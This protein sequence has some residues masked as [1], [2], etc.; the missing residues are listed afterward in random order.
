MNLLCDFCSVRVKGTDVVRYSATDFTYMTGM[1]GDTKV[2]C[3]SVS[4][5]CSCSVCAMY[6]NAND[7]AGLLDRSV[8]Y[9]LASYPWFGRGFAYREIGKLHSQFRE[10]RK[11]QNNKQ[12][13]IL[14]ISPAEDTK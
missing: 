13:R 4:D 5:W 3:N 6:V 9:F 14:I 1:I 10:A 12:P 2:E 11:E 8:L 7:W